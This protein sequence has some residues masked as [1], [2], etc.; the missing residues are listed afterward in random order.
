M[1]LSVGWEAT[2]VLG[3]RAT[4]GQATLCH[5]MAPPLQVQLRV[6]RTER[7]RDGR[8]R[9]RERVTEMMTRIREGDDHWCLVWSRGAVAVLWR[10]A[11][12][13]WG[14]PTLC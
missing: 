5:A 6:T 2:T 8:G 9:E 1:L 3:S 13:G 4:L 14:A 11:T 12:L 10:Q 7:E